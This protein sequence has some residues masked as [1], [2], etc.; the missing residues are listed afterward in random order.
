VPKRVDHEERRRQIVRALWRITE[1]G[2]LGAVSFREVAAEA[3]VSVRLVQYYFGTKADLLREANRQA[4]QTMGARI[5]RR[6]LAAMDGDPSPRDVVATIAREFLPDDDESRRA[7]LL[8]YAF[9]TAQM[10]D[11]GLRGAGGVPQGFIDLVA[12][13]IR[14]AQ[15]AGTV[16]AG[17]HPEL[18]AAVLLAVVPSAASGVLTGYGTLDEARALVDYAVDRMFGATGA[19]EAGATGVPRQ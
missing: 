13:Q 7:M 3:G 15:R 5:A 2:G 14:R 18:E 6:T 8:Y 4:L 17:V 16:A 10:T 19:T 12:D 1:R 9:Y 11:P